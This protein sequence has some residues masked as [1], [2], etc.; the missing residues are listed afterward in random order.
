MN[1]SVS[2]PLKSVKIYFNIFGKNTKE[3]TQ[4]SAKLISIGSNQCQTKIEDLATG[5]CTFSP[6]TIFPGQ[7][8]VT[9]QTAEAFPRLKDAFAALASQGKISVRPG[10]FWRGSV[11]HFKIFMHLYRGNVLEQTVSETFHFREDGLI[12]HIFLGLVITFFIVAIL[13]ANEFRSLI[14]KFR[15]NKVYKKLLNFLKWLIRHLDA[16]I[17]S[18]DFNMGEWSMFQPVVKYIIKQFLNTVEGFI[19]KEVERVSEPKVTAIAGQ[20]VLLIRLI[21]IE[22][23]F[24][25]REQ[26]RDSLEEQRNLLQ[27]FMLQLKPHD[28]KALPPHDYKQKIGELNQ[29]MSDTYEQMKAAMEK[30]NTEKSRKQDILESAKREARLRIAYGITRFINEKAAKHDLQQLS[31]H[32]ALTSAQD[33]SIFHIEGNYSKGEVTSIGNEVKMIFP[34]ISFPVPNQ[35]CQ[36]QKPVFVEVKGKKDGYQITHPTFESHQKISHVVIQATLETEQEIFYEIDFEDPIEFSEPAKLQISQ[37]Q[38]KL[39]NPEPD[40]TDYFTPL[41]VPEPPKLAKV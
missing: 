26:F 29:R 31:Q 15:R 34:F 35:F 36:T 12:E 6:Q 28:V 7:V 19:E 11:Y 37:D 4:V 8:A 18:I 9:I 13:A 40:P 1:N 23:E 24:T 41:Q 2:F 3:Q 32:F 25:S 14:R 30:I 27:N 39:I 38:I 16:I 17:L 22:I 21:K 5:F 10:S 20:L 33:S